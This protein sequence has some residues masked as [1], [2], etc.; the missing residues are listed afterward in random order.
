MALSGS[1]EGQRNQKI[2]LAVVS[3]ALLGAAGFM[4]RDVILPTAGTGSANV[5]AKPAP[6]KIDAS[7]FNR[8]DFKELRQFGDVPVK[9]LQTEKTNPFRV[10]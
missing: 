4:Y 5:I 3:L 6:K 10:Q 2:V 1:K 7:V 9:V 8:T